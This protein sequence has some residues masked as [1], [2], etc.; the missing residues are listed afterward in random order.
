MR[1]PWGSVVRAFARSYVGLGTLIAI[2][3]YG[4][5]TLVADPVSIDRC[6]ARLDFSG[7]MRQPALIA[8]VVYKGAFWPVS[9]GWSLAEGE[10]RPIDWVFGRYDPFSAYC[11]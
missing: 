4:Q 10:V 8:Y 11:G 5:F 9:L 7:E 1:E 3:A 2:I 6:L